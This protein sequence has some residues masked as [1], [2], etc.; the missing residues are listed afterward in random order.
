MADTVRSQSDLL[1][2]LFQD[3][4]TAGISAQDMRD[5]IVSLA[6]PYGG[7]YFSTPAA[8]T[9][10]ASGTYYK[11][12][13]TTTTTNLRLFDDAG[14][15]SNRLRYTGTIPM[16][17]T[18]K[19][20]ASLTFAAGTNQVAGIQIW[21]YDDSAASGALVAAS[22]AQSLIAGTTVENIATFC[23][24]TLD[25]NDYLEVHISNETGTNNM[26]VELGMLYA[27]GKLV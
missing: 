3:G 10:S 21:H 26:Q 13:G 2:T 18:V 11:A 1:T 25:T 8:T 15:T 14:G 24:L 27:E 22:E 20:Q 7:L 4:Q 6:N 19:A 12:A 9:I 17:F 5:L 16:H 23:D